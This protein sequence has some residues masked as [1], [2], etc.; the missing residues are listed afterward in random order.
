MA[1]VVVYAWRMNRW[2]A[3]EAEEAEEGAA[4]RARPEDWKG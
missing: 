4:H 2:E 1:I 3:E